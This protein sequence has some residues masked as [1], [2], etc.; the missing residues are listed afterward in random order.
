MYLVELY[1]RFIGEKIGTLRFLYEQSILFK[2]LKTNY[3]LTDDF[4]YFKLPINIINTINRFFSIASQSNE[5]WMLDFI[6]TRNKI[7]LLP[8]NKDK[9]QQHKYKVFS[10]VFIYPRAEILDSHGNRAQVTSFIS[11][12]D[13]VYML[14][15]KILFVLFYNGESLYLIMQTSKTRWNFIKNS[16]V[17]TP[18]LLIDNGFVLY[19]GKSL[20][21][22]L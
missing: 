7:Y 15:Q 18:Q 13:L 11:T 12:R 8:R 10:H 2:K 19:K 9:K 6:F 14:K 3:N 17:L 22:K 21:K 16:N 20:L 5:K 1:L 4:K